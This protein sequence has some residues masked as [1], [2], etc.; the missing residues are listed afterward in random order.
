MVGCVSGWTPSTAGEAAGMG[1]VR[2]FE[3]LEGLAGWSFHRSHSVLMRP[4]V[5]RD[6][7][8]GGGEW[9]GMELDLLQ[10]YEKKRGGVRC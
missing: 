4:Q 1:R 5:S 7:G 2:G 9:S 3:G 6:E 8:G 10:K